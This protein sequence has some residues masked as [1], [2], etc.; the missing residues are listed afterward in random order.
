MYPFGFGLSYTRF[1]LAG[2]SLAIGDSEAEA[3]VLVTNTGDVPGKEVVQV[4]Y[5]APQGLLGKPAKELAGYRKNHKQEK[6]KAGA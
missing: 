1:S 6:G 2:E 3:R 4:Y 5:S